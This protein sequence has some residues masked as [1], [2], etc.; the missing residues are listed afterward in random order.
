MQEALKQLNQ[1]LRVHGLADQVQLRRLPRT[2]IRFTEYAWDMSWCDT[3]AAD[4]LSPDE[5]KKLGVFWLENGDGSGGSP[6]FLTRLHVRYDAAHFPEDLTF[7]ETSDR[8]NFQGRY[9]MQHPF[10]GYETSAEK[11]EAMS[12]Y[13]R[14]LHT[15]HEQEAATLASLTGWNMSEIR[16][17][18]KLDQGNDGDDSSWYKNLWK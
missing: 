12:G 6:V 17:K 4:P 8:E 9:I 13:K 3:C 5:L 1:S 14:Q 7:Q 16:R 10:V 2:E 18:M 15:R 11:C